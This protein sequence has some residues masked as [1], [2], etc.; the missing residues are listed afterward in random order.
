MRGRTLGAAVANVVFTYSQGLLHELPLV[1][2]KKNWSYFE[3]KV[4]PAMA[5]V[6]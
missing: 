6:T 4:R 2:D 3:G 1:T 5:H